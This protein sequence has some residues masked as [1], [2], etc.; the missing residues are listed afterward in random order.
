MCEVLDRL[1]EL[2]LDLP[3]IRKLEDFKVTQNGLTTYHFASGIAISE[4]LYSVADIAIAKTS[5][6]KG[7]TFDVHSHEISGEWIIVLNGILDVHMG[8]ESH[9]LNKY[10]S[11][12]II[13]KEPHY[14]I[15]V[16]DTTIIAIT[17]PRD[18]GFP[19]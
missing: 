8:K 6:P 19:E 13:A 5:I 7:T 11:I 15:A 9:I 4:S 3:P 10:D 2:T 14:A 1:E 18:D 16:E 12:K 17:I